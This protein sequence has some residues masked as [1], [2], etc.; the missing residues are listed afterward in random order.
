MAI[1]KIWK[2]SDAFWEIVASLI[3]P[4]SIKFDHIVEGIVWPRF[5]YFF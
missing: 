5:E 1:V 3:P 4:L 2:I